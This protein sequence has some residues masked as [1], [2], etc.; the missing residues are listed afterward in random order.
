MI[1][2]Y[3]NIIL[4]SS[5]T[6]TFQYSVGGIPL[7][8]KY[9][10]REDPK[11]HGIF[12]RELL[13]SC[14]DSDDNARR[15]HGAG[16]R[17]GIYLDFSS[18]K[19]FNLPL[20]K[21]QSDTKG[22]SIVNVH[23]DDDEITATVY[24]PH[25]CRSH[26]LKRVDEYLT[27]T[28]K[29]GK[30][31]NNDLV[32][33]I[34]DIKESVLKSFWVGKDYDMPGD[35]RDDYEIW[36]RADSQD[37][38]AF[39]AR[40]EISEDSFVRLCRSVDIYVSR[41]VVRFP[42]R[43]VRLVY[44][45]R[46]EIETLLRMCDHIAEIRKAS[47]PCSLV[48]R[49]TESQQRIYVRELLERTSFDNPSNVS[50]CI[51][52]SG[53]N[54]NHPLL[55]RAFREDSLQTVNE[56]WGTGDVGQ[57]RGHGTEMAGIALYGNLMKC[58][59]SS[60]KIEIH[61]ELESVKILPPAGENDRRLYGEITKQAVA[62][63]EI[64]RP[65]QHRVNCMAVTAEA[66]KPG[67]PSSWSAAV[68]SIAAG[69]D[70]NCRRLFLVSAGNVSCEETREQGYI[71]ACSNHGVEDPGQSWN[72]LTVGAYTDLVRIEDESFRGFHPVAEKG[73]LSPTSSTSF[74]WDGD[75]W[76]VKPEVVFEGGNFI[77][78][79]KDV[80][81]SEDTSVLTT[82][83]GSGGLFTTASG[84]SPATA[85]AAWFCA[86]L[87]ND[88]PFLWPE[89]IRALTVHSAEWPDAMLN[90]FGIRKGSSKAEYRRILRACGYGVPD[91]KRAEECMNNS[92]NMVI[93]A[94]MQ[95]YKKN[96]NSVTYNEMHYHTLPWPEAELRKLGE[97]TVKLKVTLS[98]FIEPSPSDGGWSRGKG[99][100]S[101][102]LRFEIK[103]PGESPE[104]FRSRI[105]KIR[106]VDDDSAEM[107]TNSTSVPWRIGSSKRNSG[108]IHSD[109]YE[110]TAMD[111][112]E[113]MNIA[114]FPVGGWWKTRKKL[115]RY[116][117]LIRYSLVVTLSTPE[118]ECNLYTPIVNQIKSRVAVETAVTS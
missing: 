92:V 109:T 74:L 44:A 98:Y 86:Q 72:A 97:K 3:S 91:L 43:V 82:S 50:V 7:K 116:D 106:E 53:V 99:Y 47:F 102:G 69:D 6:E 56:E 73:E 16:F 96:G 11:G 15:L 63:I 40:E 30:P 24:I 111:L 117:R 38:F 62:D 70:D 68:D 66:G 85:E 25:T 5:C 113:S 78:N 45:D 51:L 35:R 12:V 29:N 49:D 65:E 75:T 23:K 55:S 89:T 19:G 110:T 118:T 80:D 13:L 115:E 9:P 33:S 95:P 60:G 34:E 32:R 93:Q 61:H 108:S 87:M 100:Q 10:E 59:E 37:S 8:T 28:T 101:C 48:V 76:P 20:E 57:F 88:Y 26:F 18:Q 1:E 41:T 4:D 94:E 36:L 79:G 31:K 90:E 105:T 64:A 114:V 2:G 81:T 71:D 42:E 104:E 21:F 83:G 67:M 112:V 54:R 84:T 14:F 39:A 22:I 77:T 17:K 103:R 52:D 107:K 27:K 46:S 58:L